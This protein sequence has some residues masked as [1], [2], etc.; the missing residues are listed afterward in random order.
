MGNEESLI[1]GTKLWL[2]KSKNVFVVLPSG[3]TTDNNVLDF[4]KL[5]ERKVSL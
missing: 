1:N 4:K 5:T 3:V 2:E